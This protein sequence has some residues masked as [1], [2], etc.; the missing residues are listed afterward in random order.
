MIPVSLWRVWATHGIGQNGKVKGGNWETMIE[1]ACTCQGQKGSAIY[2]SSS[3]DIQLPFQVNFLLPLRTVAVLA[4]SVAVQWLLPLTFMSDPNSASQADLSCPWPLRSTQTCAASRG[5]AS[6]RW[7]KEAAA[8]VPSQASLPTLV[9]WQPL[10][11]VL[12]TAPAHQ[13]ACYS[14]SQD[15]TTHEI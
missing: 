15:C 6:L 1:R 8:A 4:A 3:T 9:Q 5:G 12:D 2:S 13:P 14:S 10:K 7:S 11:L